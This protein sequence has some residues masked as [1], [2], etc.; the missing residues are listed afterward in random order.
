MS[1][2]R[3][4]VITIGRG[5]GRSVLRA[6]AYRAGE[7][8]IDERNGDVHDYSRR[9]G[10][11]HT[12]IMAPEHAPAWAQ[13]RQ[14]LWNAVEAHETRSNARLA[15]EV[16]LSLPHELT[17]AQR[18]E[19][20]QDFVQ[21]NFVSLGMV[22]DIAIHRPDAKGDQRNH[23]AHILLTDRPLEGNGF[24]AKKDRDWNKKETLLGWRW[25]WAQS[26]NRTL[27]LNGH[28]A[29]VS[30]YSLEAQGLNREPQPKMGPVATNMERAGRRSEKGDERRGVQVRNAMRA[31][32]Q[33]ELRDIEREIAALAREAERALFRHKAQ[34]GRTPSSGMVT[35]VQLLTEEQADRMR[36]ALTDLRKDQQAIISENR[37]KRRRLNREERE[38]IK[39]ELEKQNELLT[40]RQTRA[41]GAYWKGF[42]GFLRKVHDKIILAMNPEAVTLRSQFE[43]MQRAQQLKAERAARAR[44]EEL[45]RKQAERDLAERRRLEA[46]EKARRERLLSE[47]R[48]KAHQEQQN[49]LHRLEQGVSPQKALEQT[50]T[51]PEGAS[52]TKATGTGYKRQVKGD[53]ETERKIRQ[54]RERKDRARHERQNEPSGRGR[55]R[56]R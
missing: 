10:V 15:R 9:S 35:A 30:P 16:Q 32:K 13:N 49:L 17:D 14:Q 27:E 38:E 28:S 34:Q 44:A 33:Q 54:R 56:S 12:A 7:R 45:K 48:Q 19:L 52:N 18:I 51:D 46:E 29:R 41:A 50:R 47:Q 4:S 53:P 40:N 8:L 20:V 5:Q 55:G 22:A 6:A 3:C 31:R 37:K 2:Y 23:H 43:R 24:A 1:T 39:A 36:Q 11:L 21:E 26:V 25:E 42:R